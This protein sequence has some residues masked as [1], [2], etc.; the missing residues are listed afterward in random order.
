M[1][2]KYKDVLFVFFVYLLITF[3]LIM[4][5]SYS[6]VIILGD[7]VMFRE[8]PDQKSNPMGRF[9]KGRIISFIKKSSKVE[10]INGN[11]GEWIYI[12]AYRSDS[13]SKKGRKWT[14]PIKLE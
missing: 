13:V 5:E 10:T 4:A 6:D 14:D 9:P 12:G 8:Y 3:N 2:I 7:D 1:N 11:K